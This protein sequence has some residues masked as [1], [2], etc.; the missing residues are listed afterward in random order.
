MNFIILGSQWDF[1]KVAYKDVISLENT[2]YIGRPFGKSVLN[3]IFNLHI[4]QRINSI[5]NLP[6]KSIWNKFIIKSKFKNEENLCFLIFYDWFIL[7][8]STIEYIRKHYPKAKVVI[9]FND[10]IKMKTMRFTIAPLNIDYL[11]TITDLIIT[12]DFKEAK[13]FE[14]EY[15]S[16]P[17]SS[18]QLN[19][20]SS[21]QYD[22]YF[23]GQAKNRL[24][25]IITTYNQLIK[26]GAKVNFILANV[27][28]EKQ[29]ELPG[30]TYINGIGVSYQENLSH[31]KNSRCILEIMQKNGSGYTSRTLEAIA[32]DKKLLTNNLFIQ[33][34]P[35]YNP[36]YISY[37]D[38]PED[39]DPEFI[40][41]LTKNET[42]DYKYKDQL[43]PIKLLEFIEKH[44][45]NE[46]KKNK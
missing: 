10:L 33:R 27:P 30:I 42:I 15:H 14:L 40:K 23:L 3:K 25:E 24:D 43:S 8:I 38:K 19:I 46:D 13:E 29:I 21:P 16:I 11:K 18:P 2:Q 39:I 22:I 26:F 45:K 32:Y 6:F 12:F 17:Y 41:G 36:E 44:F 1:Y 9:V 5:I 28:K 7:N 35:F 31:L 34:A 20:K 37:F 4:N